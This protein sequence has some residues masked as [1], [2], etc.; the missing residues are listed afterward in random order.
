[1]G[2]FDASSNLEKLGPRKDP[3]RWKEN[4]LV[5]TP[6]YPKRLFLLG[7][8]SVSMTI[9]QGCSFNLASLQQYLPLIQSLLGVASSAASF[10]PNSN[11][12]GNGMRNSL[13]NLAQVTTQTG[14]QMGADRRNREAAAGRVAQDAAAVEE[15]RGRVAGRTERDKQLATAVEAAELKRVQAEQNLA[16][17]KNEVKARRDEL[18]RQRNALP[19]DAAEQKAAIDRQIWEEEKRVKQAEDALKSAQATLDELKNRRTQ[20][21]QQDRADDALIQQAE[22]AATPADTGGTEAVPDTNLTNPETGP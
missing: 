5:S 11:N 1:M 6:R 17:T 14:E 19:Q 3:R 12:N 8:L 18:I 13:G 7:C 10:N 22:A 4:Y 16:Q 15:A 2:R 9:S 20:F 21:Q